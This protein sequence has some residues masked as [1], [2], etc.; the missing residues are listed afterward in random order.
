M[1]QLRTIRI[2]LALLFLASSVAAVLLG[3]AACPVTR[4]ARG[5]QVLLCSLGASAG[6]SLIW[7]LLTL[8][9]GRIYC[10]TVCP[11]GTFSDIFMRLRQVFPRFRRK[12]SYAHAKRVRYHILLIYAICALASIT[13]V[14]LILDPWNIFT[15]IVGAAS[16]QVAA[17]QWKAVGLAAL[18]G[19][20]A[21]AVI[22]VTLAV[23]AVLRGREFCTTVCPLGTVFGMLSDYAIYHI[24]INPDKCTS[25]GLCEDECRA[26]CIKTV[27]RYI[28]NSRC[29]RC[30]DCV[31][32]CPE[33][34]IRFQPNRNRPATPLM[35]RVKTTSK[36]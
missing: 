36:T 29:V 9:F 31:A 21:G 19:M 16:P 11:V 30:F 3:P 1:K 15:D 17:A 33:G 35:R 27:S 6:A 25:C 32:R 28:D 4:I 22:A 24:E 5:S 7:L 12:F 34:A 10:A 13:A 26:S 2:I 23:L 20:V 14:T 18:A 8:M